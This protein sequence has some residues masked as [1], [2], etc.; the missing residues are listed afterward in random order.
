MTHP[1]SMVGLDPVVGAPHGVVERSQ[2]GSLIA[3]A[4]AGD[5]SVVI[6]IGIL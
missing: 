5:R 4:K 2:Q 6:A 1:D 3:R